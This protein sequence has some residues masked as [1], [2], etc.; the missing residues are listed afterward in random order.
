MVQCAGMDSIDERIIGCSKKVIKGLSMVRPSQRVPYMPLCQQH[1]ERL[2]RH[3]CCPK[4]GLFCTRGHFSTCL[5]GHTYHRQCEITVGRCPHCCHGTVD[6]D[7]LVSMHCHEQPV[8]LPIRKTKLPTAKMTISKSPVD[9]P[10]SVTSPPLVA[11][12]SKDYN[13]LTEEYEQEENGALLHA[14]VHKNDVN[15]LHFLVQAGVELDVFDNEQNTPLMLAVVQ[16]FNEAVRYLV[17]AGA[18][19]RL[20]G[21]DGMTALHLATKCGNIDAVRILLDSDVHACI[22]APDDGGW[23]PLVWACEHGH[24]HVVRELL[25]RGADSLIRDVEHNVS[26]HWAAFNGMF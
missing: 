2:L 20:R 5:N 7:V 25:R 4:C 14:A 9:C 8:F 11:V 3:N 1:R 16:N 6:Q 18:D 21:T 17:R 13:S 19:V 15:A 10:R 26:L 23:T 22:N 24:E 12:E